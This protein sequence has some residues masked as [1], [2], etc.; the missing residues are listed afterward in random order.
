MNEENSGTENQGT[1]GAENSGENNEAF[2]IEL[3]LAAT[4]ADTIEVFVE[5][6]SDPGVFKEIFEKNKSRYDVLK[7]LLN[8]PNTPDDVRSEVANVMSLPVPSAEAL[9][10]QRR[11]LAE[12]KARDIQQERLVRK[13]QKMSVSEKIKLAL[14]GG[15]EARGILMKDSNK[16]VV[17]SVLDNARITD[18]EVEAIARN[19]SVIEDAL[20]VIAKNRE[21]MKNYS[22]T[23]GLVTNPKTPPAIAMRY[24]PKLKKRD[25]GLLE[26]NKNVSEAVRTMAKKLVK[27][28]QQN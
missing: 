3:D 23:Y 28:K 22:I 13:I 12:Q 24:I 25:L 5:E 14:K 1:K 10:E 9:A 18:S 15:S 11:R 26:K 6:A 21:W 27:A 19:R 8:N 2:K 4:S 16:L 20:R 7:I 17:L